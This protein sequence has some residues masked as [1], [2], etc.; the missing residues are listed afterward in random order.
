[1]GKGIPSETGFS[2]VEVAAFGTTALLL[3]L[4]ADA[5][6]VSARSSEHEPPS[7]ASLNLGC[8]LGSGST[9]SGHEAPATGVGRGGA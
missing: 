5:H 1:M 8:T 9:G 3:S 4:V 2:R 6:L 7:I